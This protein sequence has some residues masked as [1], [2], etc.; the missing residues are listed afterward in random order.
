MKVLFHNRI[1]KRNQFLISTLL[2]FVVSV[3]CYLFS[4]IIDYKVIALILLLTVSIIAISFDILPVLTAAIFSA[5]IWNFF[6][7]PPRFTFH[8]HSTEDS[9]L[10]SM[11][12]I[13]A[14]INAVLTYKIRQLEK[15]ARQKEEKEEQN[16]Q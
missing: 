13:I 2:V 11:Y 14:L 10:F 1:T 5:L 7:I 16:A 4:S 15:I 3:I 9:I 12:F 6:F 8:V